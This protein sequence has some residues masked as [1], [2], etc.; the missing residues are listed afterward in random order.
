MAATSG[1]QSAASL[2]LATGGEPVM[3]IGGFNNEGGNLTLQ[4]VQGVRRPRRD[5]LLHRV[6]RRDGRRPG[7]L[8]AGG[9]VLTAERQRELRPAERASAR[10]RRAAAAPG[11][12]STSNSAITTWVKAHFKKV[13]IGGQ[14][15]YDLTQRVS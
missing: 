12:M 2:E 1:S 5:P 6:E 8:G 3:A 14:T 11:G 4:Q 10:G 7:V 9:S 15:M 13:T